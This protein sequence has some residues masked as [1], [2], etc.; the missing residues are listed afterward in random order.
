MDRW[1]EPQE[2]W[3][4]IRERLSMA[5]TDLWR[6]EQVIGRN[7]ED[8]GRLRSAVIDAEEAVEDLLTLV[9]AVERGQPVSECDGCNKVHVGARCDHCG[10]KVAS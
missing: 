1:H 2:S 6:A 3:D 9:D 4:L 5:H 10:V 8:F 7:T